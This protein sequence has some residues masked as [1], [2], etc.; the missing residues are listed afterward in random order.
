MKYSSKTVNGFIMPAVVATLTAVVGCMDSAVTRST[1][2]QTV[3]SALLGAAPASRTEFEGFINFCVSN[4][5]G[6]F[7]I[8]PGGTLHFTPSNENRWVTGNPLIDGIEHN[9]VSAIIDLK[10]GQGVAHLDVSLKPDAV[11]GTWEIHQ[12]LRLPERVSTG[13][14]HGTGDLQGMTIKFTTSAADGT[15]VCNPDMPRGAVHGEILL[16]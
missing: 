12:E 11:N 7:R 4:P 13:V 8:T 14:G 1:A 5:P 3:S 9:A 2:P 6:T 15:S 16:P 10:T